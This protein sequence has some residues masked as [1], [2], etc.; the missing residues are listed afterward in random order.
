MLF[1]FPRP[2]VYYDKINNREFVD[3]Y[4][5][6]HIDLGLK[7]QPWNKCKAKSTFGDNEANRFL[8]NNGAF[9][10]SILWE[11]ID[12]AIEQT[13]TFKPKASI[14]PLESKIRGAWYNIYEKGDHQEIHN[15][16][17]NPVSTPDGKLYHTALAAIYIL[18]DGG[19]P[20]STVFT[21]TAR[22]MSTD[23]G[24]R[25]DFHTALH[26]D[27]RSGTIIIFPS[28]L[29]HYVL[30]HEGDRQRITISFNIDWWGGEYQT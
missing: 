7:K 8:I 21:Q 24:S 9:L 19:V 14:D 1:E 17:A 20:N 4:L 6:E 23:G 26:N 3:S 27:I 28:E 11:H 18:D 13:I 12:K 25:A 15:H 29:D 10:D 22:I 30:P 5:R 16:V 2:F